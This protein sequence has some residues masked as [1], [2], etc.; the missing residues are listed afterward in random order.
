M[1]FPSQQKKKLKVKIISIPRKLC[2]ISV[3]EIVCIFGLNQISLKIFVC[4]LKLAINLNNRCDAI[5]L[6]RLRLEIDSDGD[7]SQLRRLRVSRFAS[8]SLSNGILNKQ[9]QTV[10]E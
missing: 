4:V 10:F 3:A 5:A 6:Q 9:N 2:D 1:A 7:A 8:H